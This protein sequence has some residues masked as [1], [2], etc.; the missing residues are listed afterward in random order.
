MSELQQAAII[1]PRS[2]SSGPGGAERRFQGMR[3][4]R[5]RCCAVAVAA[6]LGLVTLVACADDPARRENSELRV[7]SPAA[8]PVENPATGPVAEPPASA[9]PTGARYRVVVETAY[10]FEA[11]EQGV[12]SGKYLRRGDVFYG[13]G[14][15]NGFVKTGFRNPDGT[16]GVGWLKAQGL[17]KLAAAG[18]PGPV[19][20]R[21]PRPAARP[22]P[23]SAPDDYATA[24]IPSAPPER[25]RAASRG[26]TMAVVRV[27]RSYF[28]DSP[29]LLLPR[30][31]HC[32]R[33]DKVRLGEQ[34]G[35]AVFVTFTNWEQVTTTG[36]MRQDALRN[37]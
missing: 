17:S 11:P 27:A 37:R 23:L 29:D 25:P 15:A 20:R 1:S 35:E 12:P 31:A 7:D 18:A 36:W 4:T 3:S 2:P 34:R 8:E 30:K 6:W 19:P 28:Y 10:F 13:E 14:E 26:G 16:A 33:G 22:T 9:V 24:D 32:V 5:R 21:A